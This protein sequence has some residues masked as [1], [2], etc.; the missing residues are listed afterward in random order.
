[1]EKLV[2]YSV[3]RD[4]ASP[5]TPFK[6]ENNEDD[7]KQEQSSDGKSKVIIEGRLPLV[8]ILTS[9]HLNSV[10]IYHREFLVI[11]PL[12]ADISRPLPTT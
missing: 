3:A 4:T 6:N 10:R 9:N 11:L 2:E 12:P 1:M 7:R 5:V 8:H